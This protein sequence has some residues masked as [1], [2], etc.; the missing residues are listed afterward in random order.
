MSIPVV[1]GDKN[2]ILAHLGKL[3]ISIFSPHQLCAL[4]PQH[5]A[6]HNSEWQFPIRNTESIPYIWNKLQTASP[7]AT[8]V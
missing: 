1:Q 5:M 7:Y 3:V 4:Q 6:I 8:T 2:S